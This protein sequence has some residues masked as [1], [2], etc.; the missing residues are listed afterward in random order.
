MISNLRIC[1]ARLS[2]ILNFTR[3]VTLSAYDTAIG[4]KYHFVNS[5]ET[6]KRKLTATWTIS[7]LLKRESVFSMLFETGRI[8]LMLLCHFFRP[9]KFCR[10]SKWVFLQ[11]ISPITS[12]GGAH[13]NYLGSDS[14]AHRKSFIRS[15]RHVYSTAMKP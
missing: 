6:T 11:K 5:I 2:R 7:Q 3:E 8:A 9:S 1:N 14:E 4:A 10:A 12:L 13:S 15:S